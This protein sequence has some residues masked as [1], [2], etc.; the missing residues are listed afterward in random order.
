MEYDEQM[1]NDILVSVL[2]TAY[3]HEKYIADAVEGV[4]NQRTEFRYELIIHDD[5]SSDRTAKIIRE[6]EKKYPQIIRTIIQKENQFSHCHIYPSFLFPEVKGKYIAFCEGDDYWTDEEKLQKQ[7]EF[8]E[9]H[10]NYSMCMHNAVKINVE[11]GE[12][13]Y[14]DT[15]PKDGTY[16]QE[17]QIKVGLG[18]DFPAFASYVV[19]ADYLKKIPSFFLNSNVLDY[20]LRQFY[21]DQGEVYYFQKPMSVY[22]VSTLQSYMKKT[23]QSQ[24]FYNKYTLE[25]IRFFEKFNEYTDRKFYG[26]LERKMLSDY[27]GFCCSIEPEEGRKKAEKNRLDMDKLNQCFECISENYLHPSILRIRKKS[28]ELFIYGIS[29]LSDICQRQLEYAKADFQGFVVSDGQ[30]KPDEIKGKKVYY[31]SEVLQDFKNPGFILAV[32]PVNAEIIAGFLEE[33]GIRSYCMPYMGDGIEIQ[34]EC[35]NEDM[36]AGII[37]SG[38]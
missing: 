16:S 29:R 5:A 35:Q 1:E 22:R 4:I 6:Y 31:F 23:K 28:E 10:E 38:D 18:T 17:E 21:A 3:N 33:K 37:C 7:V 2:C 20:P 30:M 26:L 8:L 36:Q 15:F 13:S 9:A 19:R 27:L 14:L 25:M 34:E 11:S 12:Q 32:Q 24:S